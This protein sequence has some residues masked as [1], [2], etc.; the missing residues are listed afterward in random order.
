MVQKVYITEYLGH[1][2]RGREILK[3]FLSLEESG[4]I[5]LIKIPDDLSQ[6]NEWCR[7]YMPVR[8]GDGTL[9]LFKYFPS[10]LRSGSNNKTIPDQIKLCSN[11]GLEYVKSDIILDGGAI[12]IY[13]HIGLVSDR[14]FRDNYQKWRQDE[15]GLLLQL[16]DELR[17][18][19]LFVIPQH[20][21][22]FTGHVDGLVRFINKDKVLINDLTGEYAHMLNDKNGYRK[23]LIDQWYYSFKMSLYNAN[24]ESENLTCIIDPDR[25]PSD[26]FG[27][28]L[29][30]LLL[31]DFIL[32]PG[33]G[34][35]ELDNKAR[36]ELRRIFGKD[37]ITIQATK[38]AEK[39]GIIN[40]V[41]WS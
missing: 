25:K 18:E 40:C 3:Q 10:Y 5:I 33:F 23:K 13:E 39:G 9:I 26:A 29:N 28:Y 32:A 17:L 16:K 24:L 4:R 19:K 30:S 6:K 35:S 15:K 34:Q 20:P 41:T 11:L 22:D 27:I 1:T 8:S 21:Y 37:A 12:E 38:L 14:I 7:D 31:E 2:N 36:L